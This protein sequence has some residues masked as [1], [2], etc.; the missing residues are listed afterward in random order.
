MVGSGVPT[1]PQ[2]RV[3]GDPRDTV[4]ST[5]FSTISGREAGKIKI[6]FEINKN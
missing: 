4:R 5:G 3:A 2:L 6:K 1:A